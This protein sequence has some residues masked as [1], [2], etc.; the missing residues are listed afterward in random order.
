MDE[1]KRV[2]KKL[3]ELVVYYEELMKKIKEAHQKGDLE[4]ELQLRYSLL[5][6]FENV[7]NE[8]KRS[9]MGRKTYYIFAYNEPRG[10]W[11]DYRATV[12]G[13]EDAKQMAHDI[14]LDWKTVRVIDPKANEC[15]FEII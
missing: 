6:E 15:I 8:T 4:R 2:A 9:I 12:V 3:Q 7:L 13:A 5:P 11:D 10:G 1:E 14:R